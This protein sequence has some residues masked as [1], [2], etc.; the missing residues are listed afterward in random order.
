M[1]KKSSDQVGDA[2]TSRPLD[3]ST[4]WP[5]WRRLRH[6]AN[7]VWA[8]NIKEWKLELTYPLDFVRSLIDPVVY[9]SELDPARHPAGTFLEARIIEARDYDLVAV[10]LPTP[11]G[12][13]IV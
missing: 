5:L 11:D 6:Y 4:T 3:R 7:A 1:I 8:E 2:V 9:L 10:P 13:D 12:R